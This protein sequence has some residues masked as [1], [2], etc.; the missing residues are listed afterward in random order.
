MNV[1]CSL[2][3]DTCLTE[4]NFRKIM[5]HEILLY[6]FFK[7]KSDGQK[8]SR[9]TVQPKKKGVLFEQIAMKGMP[10]WIVQ[11]GIPHII[12]GNSK[13][14]LYF[15]KLDFFV[16]LFVPLSNWVGCGVNY[17]DAQ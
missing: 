6:T 3:G 11:Y 16:C 1:D 2:S 13:N 8:Y 9:A 5:G 12:R 14:F 15:D 7:N 4:K 17:R 10:T